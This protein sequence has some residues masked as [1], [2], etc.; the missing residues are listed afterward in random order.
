MPLHP[1]A[2]AILTGVEAMGLPPFETLSVEEGR[3]VINGFG[4][5]MIPSEEVAQ[6]FDAMALGPEEGIP[7]RLYVP[8]S[9]QEPRPVIVYFHGGGFCTGSVDLVDPICRALANRT[10]YA[11][12]SVEYRLA[13]EHPYPA[14]VTD[15]Y[16]ATAWIASRGQH[17]GIDG[18]R[19][20]V[21]GDSAG[22]TLAT[23]TCM[24]AGDN[25]G[26][27]RI[28]LQVLV[29]PALD[30][31]TFDRPS[32]TE[33]GE[34][35][36]LTTGMMEWFRNHYL[37]GVEDLAKDAYCSPLRGIGSLT[38]MPPAI[39]VVGEY[40]PLRDEGEAYG[41]LL[42]HLEGYAEVRRE[43][44]MIHG[45]FWMGGAIDRGRELLDEL[46]ADIRTWVERD[47]PMA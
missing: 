33:N 5:F 12:A 32:Y 27:P 15:A 28:V 7:V 24:T 18:N 2:Q 47:R 31:A 23:V 36:L 3:A 19:I 20:V 37:A 38:A 10:G 46:A 16:A 11:V 42:N 9:G 40:D 29:Y 41:E 39:I 6:V 22:A 8:E 14:A 45:F 17:F 4:S 25:E 34:G 44:G 35:Y 13:P 26:E 30:L 21:M 1:Q 43:E